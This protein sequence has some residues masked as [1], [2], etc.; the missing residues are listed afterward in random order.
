M[1][2]ISRTSCINIILYLLICGYKLKRI[3]VSIVI[4]KLIYKQ[5]HTRS[6]WIIL[7]TCSFSHTRQNKTSEIIQTFLSLST[8]KCDSKSRPFS[9]KSWHRALSLSCS[10]RLGPVLNKTFI[11]LEKAVLTE[12]EETLI[13]CVHVTTLSLT[14]RPLLPPDTAGPADHLQRKKLIVFYDHSVLQ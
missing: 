11:K 8:C 2:A 1:Q 4:L 13:T 6:C 3:A 12:L 7:I 5:N 14:D 9:V 10:F